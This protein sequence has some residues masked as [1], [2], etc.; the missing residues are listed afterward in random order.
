M[1]FQKSV[2]RV[3]KIFLRELGVEKWY[4]TA[5]GKKPIRIQNR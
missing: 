4:F 2:D 3:N 5:N 1:E